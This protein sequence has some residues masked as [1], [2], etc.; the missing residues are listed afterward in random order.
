MTD[1]RIHAAPRG[2]AVYARETIDGS[3]APIIRQLERFSIAE[4]TRAEAYAHALADAH[5][6]AVIWR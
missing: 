3:N 4:L 6:C 5:D 1:I 2:W